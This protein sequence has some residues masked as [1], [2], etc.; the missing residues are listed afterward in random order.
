MQGKDTLYEAK[1]ETALGGVFYL[2]NL[3]LSL[4]LYGDFTTP[5]Q[6]GIPL[7]IWDF[8]AL[9]GLQLLGEK[10]QSD[11]LWGLLAQLA[12]RDEHETP[13]QDFSAFHPPCSSTSEIAHW[14]SW[15]MPS[16]LARLS[17]ALDLTGRDDLPHV[18]CEHHARV[19]VT[20]T[21][22][23]IF[24]SLAELPIAIRLAGL[25]RNPGWVPAAGRF[26]AFHFE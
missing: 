17:H 13:S 14:L 3:G 8:V 20:A 26:I 5:L 12:G 10:I 2:I 7:N 19:L 1:I 11:P 24:L 25:D 15:L 9:V 4:N 18:L 22:V 16:L 23:D 6:P 21:H